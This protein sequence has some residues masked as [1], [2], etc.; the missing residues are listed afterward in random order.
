MANKYWM[1]REKRKFV[2]FH[3]DMKV[4]YSRVYSDPNFDNIKMKNI[5]RKGLCISTYEKLKVKDVLR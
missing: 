2:R 3:E 4:R 1:L 5:S